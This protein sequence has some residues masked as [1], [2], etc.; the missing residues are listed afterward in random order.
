MK[1][2]ASPCLS[3]AVPGIILVSS[4][5]PQL[6]IVLSPVPMYIWMSCKHLLQQMTFHC[7]KNRHGLA[8]YLNLISGTGFS[9][10]AIVITNWVVNLIGT[11]V[12]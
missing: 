8:A 4:H 7:M 1:A 9:E 5:Y 10:I 2:E 6:W 11:G 12:N 3:H